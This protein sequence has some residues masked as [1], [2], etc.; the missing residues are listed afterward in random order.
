M[1][2]H[3]WII[4]TTYDNNC[5]VYLNRIEELVVRNDFGWTDRQAKLIQFT[6]PKLYCEEVHV[7]WKN[8]WSQLSI[9]FYGLWTLSVYTFFILFQINIAQ[10]LNMVTLSVLYISLDVLIVHWC[11]EKL[12]S[13]FF[14]ICTQNWYEF[15]TITITITYPD[16]V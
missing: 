10:I 16:Q 13:E 15:I 7:Y 11:Y 4:C 3:S 5:I 1:G 2:E 9:A 8:I 12:P 14:S 6:Y